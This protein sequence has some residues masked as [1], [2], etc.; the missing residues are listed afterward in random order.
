[1]QLAKRRDDPEQTEI[2]QRTFSD[3]EEM[4]KFSRAAGTAL[5]DE[6]LINDLQS[7][8]LRISSAKSAIATVETS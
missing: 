7:V 1:M 8:L 4:L 6:Q 3:I 2:E 5:V